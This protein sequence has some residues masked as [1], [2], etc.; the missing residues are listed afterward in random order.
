MSQEAAKY[1]PEEIVTECYREQLQHFDG[2]T[3]TLV[4]DHQDVLSLNV[5]VADALVEYPDETR[6]E[7]AEAAEKQEPQVDEV[8]VR[9]RNIPTQTD[10]SD[11]R[12]KHINKIVS[13]EG[14]VR[15]ATPSREKC[16][17]AV[18][19]CQRCHTFTSVEQNTDEFRDPHQCQGCERQGPFRLAESQSEF[20]DWQKLRVSEPLSKGE[21]EPEAIN[22]RVEG[23]DIVKTAKP[24][25]RVE[26][27][28]IPRT[29]PDDG[30]VFDKYVE[31]VHVEKLD[32]DAEDIEIE[33]EELER[34]RDISNNDPLHTIA[35]N[36]ATSI[37]GYD[38]IKKAAALQLVGGVEKEMADEG[39]ERGTIHVAVVGDPGTGK[40]KIISR[41]ADIAPRSVSTSGEGS[42]AAGLTAA[43]VESEFDGRW[44][45]KAGTLVLAD[46][47]I[48]CIDELDKMDSNDRQS[49]NKALSDGVVQVSKAGKTT[50]L[51]SACSVF[52]AAN[53]VYGRFDKYEDIAEQIDLSDE[54][55]SRFDLIFITTDEPDEERDHEILS[56]MREH[57]KAG[58]KQAAG[59]SVDKVGTHDEIDNDLLQKYV[60]HAKSLDVVATDEALD[61]IADFIAEIRS[62]Y[63]GT[64][65]AVPITMR[66]YQATVRLAEAHARI[67]LSDTV[68]A[69]DARVATELME[70]SLDQVVKDP[71]TGEYD[72]DRVNASH[73]KSQR[74]LIK[75]VKAVIQEL[76]DDTDG[77]KAAKEDILDV[78]EADRDRVEEQ[79]EGLR[80]RG[81]LI[82]PETDFYRLTE[83]EGR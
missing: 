49:I 70:A 6:Q 74:D 64:D 32:K 21:G 18:F 20:V 58:Q 73:S 44:S 82:E 22:V 33:D 42:S 24:G 78:V 29:Y 57:T 19:E 80:R 37:R 16:L 40:S 43:A 30:V 1:T 56:H 9:V 76:C 54:L 38:I 60:A 13:F 71:E 39:T 23:E 72:I 66:K 50:E 61:E 55:L 26:I 51:P 27:T 83:G 79:I 45:I 67:R 68:E 47:G 35:E 69:K 48:A 5:E 2:G 63:N 14:V 34:I 17:E 75:E 7:L 3:E 25:D 8:K 36:I 4:V 65:D 59:G 10:I 62:R 53:P 28:G 41:V 52:A 46:G 31:G 77:D 81:E 11:L 12:A 15:N